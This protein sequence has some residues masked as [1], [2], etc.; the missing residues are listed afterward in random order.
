MN[1]ESRRQGDRFQLFIVW[2]P[3]RRYPEGTN[4]KVVEA[5]LKRLTVRLLRGGL[6]GSTSS[7]WRYAYHSGHRGRWNPHLHVLWNQWAP[8]QGSLVIADGARVTAR[9]KFRTASEAR[10]RFASFAS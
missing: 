5:V 8:F 9:A 1:R 4:P 3:P 10:E 7:R 2:P 6:R